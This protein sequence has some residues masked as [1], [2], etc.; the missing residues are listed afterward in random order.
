MSTSQPPISRADLRRN[1]VLTAATECFRAHGFHGTS[2][3]QLSKASGMSVGHIYHYFENKEAIIEAIVENDLLKILNIPERIEQS[4]GDSDI[5]DA[6]VEDVKQ[7]A[8]DA[9]YDPD[10]ALLLEIVAEAARNPRIASI[11]R[12]AEVLAMESI[13]NYIRKGL[14]QRNARFSEASLDT[15]CNMLASLFEGLTIRLI[16]NPD[17]SLQSSIP[18]MRRIIQY[19]LEHELPSAED[20]N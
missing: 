5:F 8:A 10:A 19:M 14:H 15:V 17:L 3:S 2:M 7:S 1:Q 13:K 4:R 11:I 12:R 6:L 9:F 18:M 20:T 16:R